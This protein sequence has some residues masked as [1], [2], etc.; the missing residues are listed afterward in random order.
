MNEKA[1]TSF[2][3]LLLGCSNLWKM[4]NRSSIFF[5]TFLFTTLKTQHN[6]MLYFD[7]AFTDHFS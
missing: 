4:L 6:V 5:N 1:F 7:G 3:G 2:S